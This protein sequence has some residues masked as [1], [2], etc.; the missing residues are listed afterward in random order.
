MG[1]PSRRARRRLSNTPVIDPRRRC[2]TYSSADLDALS[3]D[4]QGAD[5]RSRA[6]SERAGGGRCSRLEPGQPAVAFHPAVDRDGA[7]TPAAPGEG[8][9]DAAEGPVSVAARGPAGDPPRA[10]EGAAVLV[11]PDGELGP[12]LGGETQRDLDPRRRRPVGPGVPAPPAADVPPGLSASMAQIAVGLAA[13]ARNLPG[14]LAG[15]PEDRASPDRGSGR[16]AG[17]HT[18]RHWK[19]A[20]AQVPE[21][22]RRRRL[23]R[24]L[25]AGDP[26]I[27]APHGTHL[28]IATSNT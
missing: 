4:S 10:T 14:Q 5:R 18:A 15:Q 6:A 19:A 2:S 7:A 24:P 12:W 26:V 11:A 27:G 9:V 25:P 21:R 20:R 1:T 22:Y 16:R 28:P 17:A 23:L 3:I 8:A 13:S